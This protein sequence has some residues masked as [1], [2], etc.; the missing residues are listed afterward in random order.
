[1][2]TKRTSCDQDLMDR[3]AALK[4]SKTEQENRIKEQFID[5]KSSISVGG[6]IKESLA[7][8]ASDKSTKKNLLTIGTSLGTNFLIEKVLGSNNSIKGFLGSMVAEKISNSF[9]GR[10]ISKI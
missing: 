9:I 6:I 5:L 8:I 1:M 4:I 2:E 10:M 7:H 3:I